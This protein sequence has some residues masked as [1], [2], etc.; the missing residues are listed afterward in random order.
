MVRR[1][2]LLGPSGSGKTTLLRCLIGLEW[3]DDGEFEVDRICVRADDGPIR[4]ATRLRAIRLRCGIVFQQFHLFP[5][6]DVVRNLT[7]GPVQVKGEAPEKAAQDAL[8]LLDDV[9]LK[10][11]ASKRITKL[12]GGEQQR[13]AIARALAMEPE[14][15]LYDEPTS[16]LDRRRALEVWK[17]MEKLA[18]EGQ[19]QVVVAHQEELTR[20]VPC[21]VVNMREG[22]IVDA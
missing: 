4:T 16:S 10:D 15:L 11:F 17:L 7:L 13:V 2:S 9:G 1:S 22:R 6:L 12:S 21:R 8:D 20:A 14:Y 19:T 5:H 18:R 3:P